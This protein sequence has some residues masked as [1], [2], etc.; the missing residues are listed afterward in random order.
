MKKK[1]LVAMS[2]GVDSSVAA[3]L[4]QQQGF[5]VI[6]A[7]MKNWSKTA[8]GLEAC[9]WREDRFDARKVA[10]QLDIPLVTLDFEDAYT[11]RVFM[12]FVREYERGRTPNPDILCNSEI[13]FGAFLQYA[14][15]MSVDAIATGHYARVQA[16]DDGRLHLLKGKDSTKD[17]SYFLY[18]LTRE[19]LPFVLFPVGEYTKKEIRDIARKHHMS[20]AEKKDSQGICFVGNVELPAFLKNYIPPQ[21]GSVVDERGDV[22]AAHEGQ[23][24]Y[25]I[26]QRHGLKQGSGIPMYVTQRDARANTVTVV[27]GREHPSL[28]HSTLT[29]REVTWVAGTEPNFSQKVAAKIRYRQEDQSVRSLRSHGD[30]LSIAFDAPQRAITPGQS[31][32]FYAGD[33]VL[34]GAIIDRAGESS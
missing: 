18:T 21:S 32:V 34:G 9:S 16:S 26:G 27:T 5:E 31:I 1:I 24:Y 2:G 28:F 22:I 10:V 15:T 12:P 3:L 13:K 8:P 29:A 20:T 14:K 4:L 30:E 25:T 23:A 33:E 11:S 6:G 7:F 17:Q 19:H